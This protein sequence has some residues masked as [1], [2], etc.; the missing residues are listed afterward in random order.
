MKKVKITAV[1]KTEYPDLMAKYENPIL[2]TCEVLVGQS[3]VS[4]NGQR[5]EGLCESAWGLSLI[6]I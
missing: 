1:R 4:E 3:W 6:H 5:P 2:H